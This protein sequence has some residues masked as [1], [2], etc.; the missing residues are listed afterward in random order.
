MFVRPLFPAIFP[1]L[2]PSQTHTH[3]LIYFSKLAQIVKHSRMSKMFEALMYIFNVTSGKS[4][5]DKEQHRASTLLRGSDS[6]HQGYDVEAR[7]SVTR[8]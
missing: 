8:A 5:T 4:P 2:S 6:H 1:R 3:L 7:H